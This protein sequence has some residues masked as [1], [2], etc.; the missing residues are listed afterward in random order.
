MNEN[1]QIEKRDSDSIPYKEKTVR[2]LS[3]ISNYLDTMVEDNLRKFVQ[4]RDNSNVLNKS[5]NEFF[6]K[7]NRYRAT[8]KLLQ[9]LIGMVNCIPEGD[10]KNCLNADHFYKFKKLIVFQSDLMYEPDVITA[11][12]NE[13]MEMS[14]REKVNLWYYRGRMRTVCNEITELIQQ[15]EKPVP[16]DYQKLFDVLSMI[17]SFWFYVRGDD[18][19]KTRISDVYISQLIKSLNLAF[20]G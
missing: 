9:C 19:K 20:Q 16:E 4:K 5:A 8:R 2:L 13:F 10:M 17:S 11:I 18:E 7:R 14:K 3:E 15:A 1:K 6:R 12:E